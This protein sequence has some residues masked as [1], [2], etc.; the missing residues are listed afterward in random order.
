MKR[1][2]PYDVMA[3]IQRE[4]LR[5]PSLKPYQLSKRCKVDWLTAKKV[6]NVL[7]KEG[8]LPRFRG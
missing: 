3:L 7:E 1:R 2:S 6:S 8:L 4:L 5:N